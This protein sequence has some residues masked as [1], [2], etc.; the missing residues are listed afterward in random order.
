MKQLLALLL[1]V[2]LLIGCAPAQP[3]TQTVV[4]IVVTATPESPVME[5]IPGCNLDEVIKYTDFILE[6]LPLNTAAIT[7]SVE[8]LDASDIETMEFYTKEARGYAEQI[9]NYTNTAVIPGCLEQYNN[10]MNRWAKSSMLTADK[11]LSGDYAGAA[12]Q[13]DETVE[14]LDKANTEIQKLLSDED[15][16]NG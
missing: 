15:A 2:V 14:W 4:Q 8:A 11:I 3:Q 7:S 9:Y 1:V 13:I 5:N 6:V 12:V 10:Y 16:L